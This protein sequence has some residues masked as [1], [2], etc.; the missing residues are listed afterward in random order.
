MLNRLHSTKKRLVYI[1]NRDWYFRMHWSFRA[2]SAKQAGY[3]VWVVTPE[4]NPKETLKMEQDG[5]QV[6]SFPYG[7]I[8]VLQLPCV[9]PAILYL[10]A[11]WYCFF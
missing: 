8:P 1:T 3:D 4:Y 7:Q 5:F 11:F 10:Q 2:K 9:L 6:H